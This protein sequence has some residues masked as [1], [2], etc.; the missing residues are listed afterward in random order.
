MIH[1]RPTIDRSLRQALQHDAASAGAS[2]RKKCS[3]RSIVRLA[4]VRLAI[5]RLPT[6]RLPTVRLPT[7]RLRGGFPDEVVCENQE[8]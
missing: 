8:V 5:V 1:R 4:I 2:L 6:V 7:V 3:T